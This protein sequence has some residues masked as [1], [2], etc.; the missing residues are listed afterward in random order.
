[1][2]L[3]LT[4]GAVKKLNLKQVDG[5]GINLKQVFMSL[6]KMGWICI[7]VAREDTVMKFLGGCMG[8]GLLVSLV[9]FSP[10]LIVLALIFLFGVCRA[11]AYDLGHSRGGR[12]LSPYRG[13]RDGT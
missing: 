12:N 11:I 10:F 7:M 8:F 2:G 6:D 5:V 13:Y 1:M 4:E 3:Q 9:L